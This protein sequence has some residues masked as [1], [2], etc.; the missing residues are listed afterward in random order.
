LDQLLGLARRRAELSRR[1]R[2]LGRE[3]HL[4]KRRCRELARAWQRL[5]C[6]EQAAISS[7]ASGSVVDRS[8]FQTTAAEETSPKPGS[9]RK[10]RQKLPPSAGIDDLGRGDVLIAASRYLRAATSDRLSGIGLAEDKSSWVVSG[11]TR[12]FTLKQLG[13]DMQL[14]V[15]LSLQAAL[16]QYSARQAAGRPV[17]VSADV[18][19]G[20][21]GHAGGVVR[22]LQALADD[23]PLVLVVIGED[24]LERCLAGMDRSFV[25]TVRRPVRQ[26]LIVKRVSPAPRAD[27][28]IRVA[29]QRFSL[30]AAAA[31]PESEYRVL[32]PFAIPRQGNQLRD[33]LQS[34]ASDEPAPAASDSATQAPRDSS[35]A[36]SSRQTS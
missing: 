18:L 36:A 23:V 19:R 29:R 4:Q 11:K 24:E 21:P 16:I 2:R 34:A 28:R 9:R 33:L 35:A 8:A 1:Q 14:Q 6:G 25:L 30:S 32:G 31:V 7:A 20:G 10:P 15:L 17:F 3:L 27:R 26:T 5:V 12:R 13:D 22:L